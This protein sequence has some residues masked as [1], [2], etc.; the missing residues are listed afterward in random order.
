MMRTKKHGF[1]AFPQLMGIK[2]LLCDRLTYKAAAETTTPVLLPLLVCFKSVANLIDVI[3][4]FL[5][6]VCRSK[7]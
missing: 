7:F 1:G 2:C 5:A 3:A 6:T 4:N